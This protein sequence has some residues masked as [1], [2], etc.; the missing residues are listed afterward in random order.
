M[1]KDI[2][3][4]WKVEVTDL[5]IA[6]DNGLF[7]TQRGYNV[8]SQYLTP[9]DLT[10]ELLNNYEIIDNNLFEL[11]KEFSKNDDLRSELIE[12]KKS[13]LKKLSELKKLKNKKAEFVKKEIEIINNN[14]TKLAKTT[15][16][17][18]KD[19]GENYK[20]ELHKKF[21]EELGKPI[22]DKNKAIR[23]TLTNLHNRVCEGIDNYNQQENFVNQF[24][25]VVEKIDLN[26]ETKRNLLEWVTNEE[27]WDRSD[28]RY[29]YDFSNVAIHHAL[30]KLINDISAGCEPN[31]LLVFINPQNKL[32][33]KNVNSVVREQSSIKQ[34]KEVESEDSELNE[35][36]DLYGN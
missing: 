31:E 12:I 21:L 11:K 5:V 27:Y 7:L 8:L 18:L 34:K 32:I 25:E 30:R 10:E 28:N 3:G 14:L 20:K 17:E 26:L 22:S 23:E 6:D 4:N 2:F 16:Q 15:E 1:K 35:N 33:C 19:L 36:G 9:L 13:V 29:K 24:K